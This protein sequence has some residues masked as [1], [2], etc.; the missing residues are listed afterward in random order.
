MNRLGNPQSNPNTASKLQRQP[1]KTKAFDLHHEE[2]FS[3]PAAHNPNKRQRISNSSSASNGSAT[4]VIDLVDESRDNRRHG[5]PPTN[6]SGQSQSQAAQHRKDSFGN[7][8][9]EEYRTVEDWVNPRRRPTRQSMIGQN[10]GGGGSNRFL[11]K[12]AQGKKRS[13]VRLD[14]SND[15]EDP[16]DPIVSDSDEFPQNQPVTDS[17]PQVIVGPYKGTA[18]LNV[19]V[20]RYPKASMKETGHTSRFFNP[21]QDREQKPRSTQSELE[22][23]SGPNGKLVRVTRQQGGKSEEPKLSTSIGSYEDPMSLDEIS[24]EHFEKELEEKQMA[25]RLVDELEKSRLSSAKSTRRE[26]RNRPSQEDNSS[27]EDIL[28]KKADIKHTDFGNS[29]KVKRKKVPGEVWYD[30]V[31]IF[32]ATNRWL[33]GSSKV[34]WSLLHDSNSGKLI[35]HDGDGTVMV[36]FLTKSIEKIE[37]CG[38]G[39][40]SGKMVIHKSRNMNAGDSTQIFLELKN[41]DQSIPLAER[42]KASDKVLGLL[43]KTE[44]V[45]EIV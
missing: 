27:E 23:K 42:I 1:P 36:G 28:A 9:V 6:R 43:P 41:A 40:T 34:S 44:W 3:K 18:F 19:K 33:V 15:R 4:P 12:D 14:E 39:G 35:A 8:G 13:V 22:N 17:S 38:Q 30:V 10:S 25:R 7:K 29:K 24:S 5:S 32:S 21:A 45:F 31:Q 26:L 20:N 16:D 11:S 37:I 2:A